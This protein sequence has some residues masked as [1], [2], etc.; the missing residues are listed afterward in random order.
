MAALEHD[1]EAK[2]L[3]ALARADAAEAAGAAAVSRAAQ[4]EMRLAATTHAGQRLLRPRFRR[5]PPTA[6]SIHR[7]AGVVNWG[8]VLSGSAIWK[9]LQGPWAVG[10]GKFSWGTFIAECH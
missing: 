6:L 8:S 4:L 2:V 9:S 7:T 1:L 5:A 10:S 3:A